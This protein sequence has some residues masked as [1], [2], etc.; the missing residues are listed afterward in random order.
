M[1]YEHEM[2]KSHDWGGEKIFLT[3]G[4][5]TKAN[6]TEFLPKKSNF[7]MNPFFWTEMYN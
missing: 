2:I 4:F 5:F 3:F 7:C 1:Q 6:L